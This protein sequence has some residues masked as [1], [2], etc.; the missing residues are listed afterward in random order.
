MSVETHSTAFRIV[1]P[2]SGERRRVHG[3]T[4]LTAYRCCDPR[5]DVDREAYLSGFWFGADF[6]EHLSG[7]GS[8][9]GFTGE[10]WSP[11]L[12]FDIDREGD[13]EAALTDAR[14]LVAAMLDSYAV[15]FEAVTV[16]WSGYKGLAI[17]LATAL[18]RPR[19][20][21]DFP[22]IAREFCESIARAAGVAIDPA[23]YGKVQPLRAPNSR[24]P[25][26]GLYKRR[27]E[28]EV[29]DVITPRGIRDL[30]RA[31]APFDPPNL[32][33]I[34][35]A[36]FLAAHWDA[37]RRVVE[38]RA[39]DAERR[40]AEIASGDRI[41]TVNRRTRDFLACEIDEGDR[42]RLLFSAARNLAEIGCPLRAVRELLTKPAIDSGLTPRDVE[43]G[44]RCGFDAATGAAR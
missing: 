11:S 8:P 41:A 4:A 3:P 29:L 31:P 24:H 37:A 14:K 27:V 7:T 1:G 16:F 35:S 39:A 42:H 2:C 34:P 25:K 32:A 18:W 22:A 21:V 15:P 5:A 30:A 23:V 9:A 28:I 44:I 20:A 19:A 17:D 6:A 12:T 13:V 10:A 36:D 38:S 33:D 40:R 43:R 26:S